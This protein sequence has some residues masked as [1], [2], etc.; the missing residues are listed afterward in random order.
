MMNE[1]DNATGNQLLTVEEI[2]ALE[3]RWLEEVFSKALFSSAA[4]AI[5]SGWR[6]AESSRLV[7]LWTSEKAL[8]GSPSG[9][10]PRQVLALPGGGSSRM[11]ATPRRRAPGGLTCRL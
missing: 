5:K 2:A 8:N 9:V 6:A 3:E 1:Y 10:P 7:G 11:G 4:N